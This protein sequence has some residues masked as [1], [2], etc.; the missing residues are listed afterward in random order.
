M[1]VSSIQVRASLVRALRRDLIG[2]EPDGAEDAD[3]HR[4]R[5]SEKPSSWYLAGFIAPDRDEAAAVNAEGEAAVADD[6]DLF[7][8]EDGDN[9]LAPGEAGSEEEIGEAPTGHRRFFPA[10]IGLTVLVDP[11]VTA[12]DV[13]VTWGDYVTEPPVPPAILR[14][15]GGEEPRRVDWIRKPRE[16]TVTLSV[17]RE[18]RADP[19]VVP[20]SA[21]PMAPGGGL[22]LE[23]QTRL[24]NLPQPDGAVR[25][26]RA[27]SVFLVNRRAT[28]SKRRFADLTYA[29][30]ARLDLTCD[31]GFVG[32]QDLSGLRS[33]D[34]DVRLA[35]L[36]Y[37][38]VCE[39]AVGRNA[40][41]AWAED[42]D[43]CV[44]RA[45]TSPMPTAEVERV[46]PRDAD[47]CA[48][49]SG[50]APEFEMEALAALAETDAEGLNAALSPLVDAYGDWIVTQVTAG[51]S[52]QRL[53]T[54]ER[55]LQGA[56]AARERMAAG[57]ARL[58]AN[59]QSRRAFRYANLAVARAARR[60]NAG[61]GGDPAAQRAPA[62]RPFQLAFILLNLEGLSDKA[63]PDREIVDL[64]FFPTGGG[65]TEAYL[66]LAAFTIAHRRLG[67]SGVLGAGLSVIMRY[68]LRLLT[69]DQLSRAAGV[70]CALDLLR[71]DPAEADEKGRPR[72]GDW[73]IEIGLWLGAAGTPNRMGGPKDKKIDTAVGRLEAFK[74]GRAGPP[75]PIKACPWC[76][77]DF[78]RDAFRCAPSAQAPVNLEIRCSNISCDFT[79]DRPL[80]LLVVDDPIYRRLPAFLIATIDKFASLPWEGR[81][82]A[83]F[84]HVDRWREGV[85]FYGA[86]E[87]NEG[88]PLGDGWRLD[89]PDLIIQD[90]LHLIS[91]PLGTVAGLYEAAIDTL[92]TRQVGGRAVRPKIVAST[93]TVRRADD[94]IRGLFGRDE[95]AVFPPPGLD[96]RDSFFAL[97]KPASEEAAR[98]Y[99]GL[100]AQGRGPK[101]VYLR[102]LKT[103][104]AAAQ[105]AY[106]S[107]PATAEKESAADPYMT[108]LCYFNALRELGGARRIVEGEVSP[109]VLD[110]GDKRRRLEPTEPEFANRRIDEPLE[111]TS[112]V[113]TDQ[114]AEAKRRLEAAFGGSARSI[115][116]AL[117]TNMISVGLD[118]TRLGL[119]V[120]Q[121]QPKGAAEYIQATSRVGRVPTNP[122]LIAVIL[123]LHK[124][125]DRAHF[126][127]FTAYHASFYRAVEAT[128]VT[129][130][131]ARALDRSL[132]AVVVAILRH[133]D[134][135]MTPEGAVRALA[136]RP[137][138]QVSVRE[139][140]LARAPYAAIA[141][142]KEALGAQIDAILKAWLDTVEK[143][144]V[145]GQGFVYSKAS[146]EGR[147]LQEVL[148]K[149][150]DDLDADH[151]KFRA[152]R[153]MRD[154]EPPVP[155]KIKDP[156]GNSI[157]GDPA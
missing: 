1:S 44:R 101:L 88:R 104:L 3:L 103:L 42:A 146:A 87:P 94:Q 89:P 14:S 141:G 74:R 117:A 76:G 6:T 78:D 143:Q 33:D 116:V 57:V 84:G 48:D 128:S 95:T 73:P 67:A 156:Y 15:E 142:G 81:T 155:L 145:G 96:R 34:P 53:Q 124:P 109:Q 111:L 99:L 133:M 127:Q 71:T 30:Q 41:G 2:P 92:A 31:T 11:D 135:E 18:G 22:V 100:A 36:Q 47:L 79:G 5:L 98:L 7:A 91:G 16:A 97:T 121:G 26:L 13:R 120:V 32:R 82:G 62:W 115:D 126:E 140:L 68:T 43:G 129:P 106:V 114:V 60:R 144:T 10:S 148:G 85:G 77:T 49:A 136:D 112:R 123:N 139:V 105:A 55:L 132:A 70:V 58:L 19:V 102:A 52:G 63:H 4:E 107:D 119:M 35:D 83:F 65:K 75:A 113:S 153:S 37:R 147:L 122:G 151:R 64:L 90:E 50:R 80:P 138:L 131:A 23:C 17:A 69:L 39:Y 38:D 66:G 137:D 12:L 72:L 59:E 125:R 20:D 29:F 27:V 118:I 24:F 86:A 54:A 157:G 56:S 134:D 51:L 28:V 45:W 110:Y 61:P 108:A 130:W 152:G 46:A 150:V 21:A 25:R 9:P 8:D 40:S 149:G 93:A 154:V